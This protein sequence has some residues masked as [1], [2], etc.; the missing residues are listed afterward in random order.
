MRL[1]IIGNGFD[2][3]HG[4][5]TS[6]WDFRKYLKKY[7]E[8]FLLEF[9]K[10]Y[11]FYP[12]QL[13]DRYLSENRQRELL[14]QREEIL[15]E[16]LWNSFEFSL[17]QADEGEIQSICEAAVDSMQYLESGPVQIEDTLI[18][19]FNKQFEFVVKL[20]DYLLKW[21]KQIRLNKASVK[22]SELDHNKNDLFLTFNYT[23]TLERVYVIKPAQICHVHGGIPPYCHVAPIIGHGNKKTIKQ[24]EKWRKEC[25]E[26]F[27]EGGAST[28]QAFADFYRRTLKDTD[29]MLITNSSF[30]EKIRNVDEVVVIGHSLGNVDMPY[31]E[32][33]IRKTVPGIPWKVFYF[34]KAEKP[35]MEKALKNIGV[36]NLLLNP[37]NDFWE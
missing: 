34:K 32:E 15:Y 23:P 9:E 2:L 12:V 7:A 26:V 37:S 35:Q 3:A 17:G 10:L 14:R 31:F 36:D 11:G 30:F 24:R 5:K 27:D 8:G 18:E 29:K 4:L 13:H 16:E 6:Y 25:V 20:Q 22:N 28:N 33:I 21:A 1:Y 19:Y